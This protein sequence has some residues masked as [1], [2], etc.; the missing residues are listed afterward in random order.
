MGQLALVYDPNYVGRTAWDAQLEILRAAVAHLTPKE[1]T[2][3]LGIAK[4]TLSEAIRQPALEDENGGDRRDKEKG[5]R[6]VA[7]EW[8]HIIKAM[9]ARR[10][11]DVSQDLLRQL[12]DADMAATP[13][14]IGEPRG[15]TPEEERD[16]YRAELARMGEEGKAA[17]AR[18]QSQGKGKKRR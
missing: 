18:V 9:L 11:D 14:E 10:F 1:V 15:L 16:G 3:A 6:R 8:V 7:A 2:F 13:Y 12:C 5:D 17:I 4:S